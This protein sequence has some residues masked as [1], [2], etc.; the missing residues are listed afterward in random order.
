MLSSIS[1]QVESILQIPLQ[2]YEHDFTFIVNSKEF[3]TTSVY[4]DLISPIIA[5]KHLSD[6][7]LDK[8]IINTN[9]PGDFNK[10]INLMN[11][12]SQE[13]N[14][15]DEKFIIEVFEQLGT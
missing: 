10:V 12:Q 3:K 6:P 5:S 4:A 13:F 7:T 9:T 11:F 2:S 15:I 8:Y 1:L 14:E